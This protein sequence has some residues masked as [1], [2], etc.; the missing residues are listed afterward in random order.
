VHDASVTLEREE[1]W[2]SLRASV[3]FSQ[4]LHDPSFYRLV[5]SGELGY[6]IA[7]GLSISLDGRVS[8]IRDQLSLPRREAS[9]EEILLRLRELQSDYRIGFDVSIRYTFGSL[10]NNIVNPRFG[11]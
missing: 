4:Y 8:R 3:E 6:R 2:G 7:R 5:A 1:P 9:D 11:R 10:L